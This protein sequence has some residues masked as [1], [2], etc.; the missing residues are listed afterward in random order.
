MGVAHPV[1]LPSTLPIT[2]RL[3]ATWYEIAD[4]LLC[5]RSSVYE[6]AHAWQQGWRPLPVEKTK[7]SAPLWGLAPAL[8]RSLLALRGKSPAA[9]GWCRTRW[10]CA[11]LAL[12]LE[13]RR[14]LR[15]SAETVRRWWQCLG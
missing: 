6:T 3:N 4:W 15:V 2:A 8:R 11:T 5:S 7:Q 10:S 12:S 1:L 9:Y 14:G 13:A